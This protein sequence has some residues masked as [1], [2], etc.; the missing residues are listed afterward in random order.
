MGD[1]RFSILFHLLSIL[2]ASSDKE[3]IMTNMHYQI[4]PPVTG[5]ALNALFTDAWPDHQPKD[6]DRILR[7]SLGYVCAYEDE[8][9]IGFVNV[10]W[11]GGAH[12]FLLDTTVRTDRRR[13][14]IGRALVRHAE[15]LAREGGAEWLH[16]DFEPCYESFY[17]QCGFRET[18][19]GLIHLQ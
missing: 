19:A 1:V 12:A 15:E 10:A 13:R 3:K 18:L 5:D 11:D 17:R 7:H 2:R 16:V 9:L 6:F 8:E 14:G 4:S